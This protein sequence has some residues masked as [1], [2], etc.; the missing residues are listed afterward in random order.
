MALGTVFITNVS[1]IGF[2]IPKFGGIGPAWIGAGGSGIFGR[3]RRWAGRSF[4]PESSR[5]GD[6]LIDFCDTNS[7]GSAGQPPD[8]S[9]ENCKENQNEKQ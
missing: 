3:H 2:D 8:R 4:Q 7:I 6:E 5:F 1:D 9:A